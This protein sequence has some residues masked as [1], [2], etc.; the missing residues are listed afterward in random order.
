LAA[1][2]AGLGLIQVP[3]IGVTPLLEQGRLKAVLPRLIGAPMPVS[4]LYP[5]RRHLPQRVKVFMDWLAGVLSPHL[6]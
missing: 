5:H 1:C 3:R 4:L 6:G 2:L